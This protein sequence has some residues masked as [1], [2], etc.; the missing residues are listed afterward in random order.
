M[1]KAI[2]SRI[3]EIDSCKPGPALA[4]FAGTHGN[5]MAGVYALQKL[6]PTLNPTCGKIYIAFVNPAA[7][8]ANSR[9]INKNLNRC[10]IIDNK[11]DFPEDKRAI[12]L[13]AVLDKCDALLD[14]H[15]SY[16]DTGEPFVICEDNALNLASKFDVGIISTNW[17]K[18]EPG[19]ADGYMF[20]QGK[21]GVCVECGPIDKS[22]EY[23]DFAVK[24]IFQFLEYF[25]VL[26]KKVGF[27]KMSK[28]LIVANKSI[29]KMSNK[30][31][32]KN[33]YKNFDRLKTG[34]I[35]AVDDGVEYM[36]KKGECIIFPHYNARVGEE[37]CVIGE[38]ITTS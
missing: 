34:E 15:M 20:T 5:E 19:A 21:I 24:T 33:G 22:K 14:L 25:E 32:I 23:T 28:R 7:I 16:G 38:E 18:V 26:P 31:K 13:M 2:T 17:T 6:T 29:Y 3:I 30:F 27:S 35:I 12:E 1:N 36:A 37:A 8:Q 11:G 10:F 9:M 4:I